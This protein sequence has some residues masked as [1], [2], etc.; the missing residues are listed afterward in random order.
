[1]Y[2]VHKERGH[3]KVTEEVVKKVHDNV[4]NMYVVPKERDHGEV[5]E[6][7]T[8]YKSQEGP[9]KHPVIL[10]GHSGRQSLQCNLCDFATQLLKPSRAVQRLSNH[11]HSHHR[12]REVENIRTVQTEEE[13]I[14]SNDV[15]IVENQG[16]T[17]LQINQFPQFSDTKMKSE[18]V[19]AVEAKLEDDTTEV[20]KVKDIVQV[21]IPDTTDPVQQTEVNAD[22]PTDEVTATQAG[23]EDDHAML[24]DDKVPTPLLNTEKKVPPDIQPHDDPSQGHLHSNSY[25]IACLDKSSLWLDKEQCVTGDMVS[26]GLHQHCGDEICCC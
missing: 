9:D 21:S 17:F 18:E 16:Q 24:I 22:V 4:V 10:L 14:T 19:I 8:M 5:T 6:E 7:D 26:G 15:N 12:D 3:G 2:V 23:H 11:H 20:T 13:I 25:Q 1:M